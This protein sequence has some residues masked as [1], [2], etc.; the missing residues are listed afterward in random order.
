MKQTKIE[1]SASLMNKNKMNTI[2]FKFYDFVSKYYTFYDLCIFELVICLYFVGLDYEIFFISLLK[3]FFAVLVIEFIIYLDAFI[4][5]KYHFPYFIDKFH[6]EMHLEL[7]KKYTNKISNVKIP[8]HTESFFY[9][10]Y[11]NIRY[12][13]LNKVLL[14]HNNSYDVV[15]FCI[16]YNVFRKSYY[17]ILSFLENENVILQYYICHFLNNK[18][19]YGGPMP[20]YDIIFKTTELTYKP[21]PIPYID[22]FFYKKQ[23]NELHFINSNLI[24][25]I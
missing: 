23:M 2:I 9:Y 10:L 11:I 24:D 16:L 18:Q 19:H 14:I 7:K 21:F 6:V 13:Y 22:Y 25:K 17:Y 20:F 5:H 15:V 12:Y 4:L 1:Y 8:V 3:R